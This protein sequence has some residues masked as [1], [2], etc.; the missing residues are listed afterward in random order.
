MYGVASGPDRINQGVVCVPGI[1]PSEFETRE[2][3]NNDEGVEYFVGEL[4]AW[5]G[6]WPNHS[7][8]NIL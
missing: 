5:R 7:C 8:I 2:H 6:G 1:T 4:S 3:G